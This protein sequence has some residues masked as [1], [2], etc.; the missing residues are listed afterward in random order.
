MTPQ[1]L[2]KNNCTND[3]LAAL[4]DQVRANPADGKLRVFLSQLLCILG[5]WQ[6]ALNQL[7]VAAELDPLAIPMKQV[8]SDA[9]K[10][11][12]LRADV[13][14][15]KRT[16]MVFGQPEEWL[17]LLVESLLRRG[18]GETALAANLHQRAFEN[19]PV[20]PGKLD[21]AAFD[22]LAD[23]DMRLGPVLEAFINGKYYWVPFSRLSRIKIESPEDLRDCVWMPAQLLFENGGESPA[24]IPTRYHDTHNKSDGELQLARKTEWVELEEGIWQGFGQRV[25]S[26]NTADH[27]LMDIREIE[28]EA[29]HNG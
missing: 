2:L 27:A 4:S 17:A 14:A 22:W 1:E 15:G 11:E 28:F 26:S 6:R 10:C 13:F 3:A 19:A 25:F 29:L 23:A 24:L 5:N 12:G 21:G 20:S 9:I 16:P 18:T 8:Y 7:S